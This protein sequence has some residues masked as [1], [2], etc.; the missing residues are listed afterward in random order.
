[1][2]WMFFSVFLASSG[3][4]F[5]VDGLKSESTDQPGGGNTELDLSDGTPSDLA[6][7][8]DDMAGSG[9]LDMAG[10]PP[11]LAPPFTPT[12]VSADD[13]RLGTQP[14]TVTMSIQ[15][16]AANLL[17]DGQ[18]APAGVSFAVENGLAGIAASQV[19]VPANATVRVTGALP[20]VIV[21]GSSISVAGRIDIS[22]HGV[23]PGAGG[24][25]P[26]A[27]GAGAGTAGNQNA[28]GD[29]GGS[30]AG[31]GTSGGKSGDDTGT[32]CGIGGTKGV[33]GGTTTGA[34]ALTTLAGGAGG[35]AGKPG[36]C[37]PTNYPAAVGGAGGGALQLTAATSITVAGAINA[38]GGGGQGGCKD[39]GQANSG[40]GAGGGSGGAIFLETPALTVTGTLAANGG[41]GG[42]GAVLTAGGAG[43]DGLAAATAATAGAGGDDAAA[44]GAEVTTDRG[45]VGSS[46]GKGGDTLNDNMCRNTGGSGGGAGRIRVRSRGAATTTG[47]TVSPDASAVTNL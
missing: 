6:V 12:H 32:G 47:S 1:M 22:A 21:S 30:G 34:P 9:S 44:G 45:G 5:N 2:R 15:T 37:D 14:L 29:S 40:S 25:G 16:D 8:G 35:G 42:G 17:I 36:S 28:A 26:G 38:G 20:L 18:P 31:Y 4:F 41:G 46:T 19:T 33:A 24:A 10:A 13:F 11:D 7:V 39:P 43:G 23:S 3:C 27:G